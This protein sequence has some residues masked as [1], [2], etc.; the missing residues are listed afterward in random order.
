MK[1]IIIALMILA[2]AVT[3]AGALS[4]TVWAEEGPEDAG[5]TDTPAA[6]VP[7]ETVPA[8]EDEGG[9]IE[10]F[11]G[12]QTVPEIVILCLLVGLAVK[13]SPLDNKY[14]PV[15]VGAAGGAVG[16]AAFYVMPSF[17]GSNLIYALAS[18]VISGL[19]ATGL[20]QAIKQL[21]QG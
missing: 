10:S 17:Q 1:K 19:A 13:V 8:P 6:T 14:I 2:L 11:M 21:T 5:A 16:I 9:G 3:F 12:V 4:V 18:G 7:A 15:I 20:H